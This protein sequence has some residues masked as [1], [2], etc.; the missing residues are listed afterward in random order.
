MG[1]SR[2]KCDFLDNLPK[3][4]G[5][6]QSKRILS[7]KTENFSEFF[8]ERGGGLAQSKISLTE[9][10]WASKL[11]GGRGG[12]ARSEKLK[13]NCFFMPPLNTP[14][15]TAQY[16]ILSPCVFVFLLVISCLLD[17]LMKH[18]IRSKQKATKL[19]CI[20]YHICTSFGHFHKKGLI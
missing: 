7:E 20:S 1:F 13:K 11:I 14:S 9:K 6:T 15:R 10:I 4:G 12:L 8:A 3:R 2:K 17:F 19:C 16:V 18:W 5:L